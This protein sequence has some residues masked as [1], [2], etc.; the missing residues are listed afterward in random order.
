MAHNLKMGGMLS[1]KFFVVA[2][3]MGLYKHVPQQFVRLNSVWME[4]KTKEHIKH[5]YTHK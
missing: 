2:Y 1:Y 4:T 3:I 5:K